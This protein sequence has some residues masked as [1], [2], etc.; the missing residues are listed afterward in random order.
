MEVRNKNETRNNKRHNNIQRR[1]RPKNKPSSRHNS[2]NRRIRHLQKPIRQQHNNTNKQSSQNKKEVGMKT[3]YEHLKKL[4]RH[5]YQGFQIT[6]NVLKNDQYQPTYREA[7]RN[8]NQTVDHRTI[9]SNE[10]IFDLDFRSYTLTYKHVNMITNVLEERKIPYYIFTTGG[11][12][13]HIHTIF[14]KIKLETQEIKNLFTEA[15]SYGFTWKHIRIFLTE[16]ICEEAGINKAYIGKYIDLK[17]INFN[18]LEQNTVL[19]RAAC[20]RNQKYDEITGTTE[21]N[22]KSWIPKEEW[23]NKRIHVKNIEN[24]RYP[25]DIKTFEI[26]IHELGKCLKEYIEDAKTKKVVKQ[27]HV[28]L[29]NGYTGLASVQRIIEGLEEGNRSEGAKILSNAI[30]LDGFS[31]S[32]AEQILKQYTDNC[33]Q[34]GHQFTLSEAMNWYK[35]IKHQPTHFWNNEAVKKLGVW[36]KDT[37]EYHNTVKKT[38]N[39]VLENKGLL[40]RID[41]YLKTVI[42]GEKKTRILLFL[43]L[44]SSKFKVDKE[45]NI[46]GDPKPQSIILSSMS[47]SGKSYITKAI[48]NLFGE[49]EQDYYTF[50][51][52]TST[53]LNYF[54]DID[55][56]GKI[57]FVE[58][59]QGMDKES[60]Q[61]RLW[62]SEGELKLATVEKVEQNGESVNKLVFKENIGQPVFVT[63]TAEDY[64]DEQMNNRSWLI[65]LDVSEEQNRAI[66]EYESDMYS[67][68]RVIDKDELRILKDSIAEL[69]SYHYIIP[70]FN[71]EWLNIPT[72]DVRIRRDFKKFGILIACVTCLFQKQRIMVEDDEG[73]E[74]LI[75][76]IED[77]EIAKKYSEDVL[78]NTF[79]GLTS[80]QLDV[81]EIIKANQWV[82]EF[83]SSDVQ[84]VTGWSQSKTYMTLKQLDEIGVITS[85]SGG[86][87][88]ATKYE[89]NRRKQLVNLKLPSGDELLEI[90]RKNNPTYFDIL[91]KYSTYYQQGTKIAFFQK[92]EIGH[93]ETNLFSKSEQT[94]KQHFI[95]KDEPS[96]PMEKT[97]KKH[98]L[99]GCTPEIGGKKTR[100]QKMSYSKKEIV[101]FIKESKEHMV[102]ENTII[103]EFDEEASEKL[104]KL[105]TDGEVFQPKPGYWMTI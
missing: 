86:V 29:T 22:Y 10:I 70:Y 16:L 100:L 21:T 101:K 47:A 48:L 103:E 97:A 11:K 45:W 56:N 54:S 23:K 33:S 102:A 60:N 40:K 62:I 79:S 71:Y 1:K 76:S 93:D 6:K 31:D 52:M 43:L 92:S 49:K 28:K 96:F 85:H 87:G 46:P 67:N 39:K 35:W 36:D 104:I 91:K 20:G 27:E 55:M 95:Y 19:I 81:L 61:L 64:V 80:Q 69:D 14:D 42:V 15:L 4:E 59:L 73:R 83:E 3:Q 72:S 25:T 2:N 9:A 8:P 57:L 82:D 74:Y 32:R 89:L 94:S 63:G 58:E 38:V 7:L 44:L 17:K 98:G 77:Y 66:L 34:I 99:Q 37:D 51:R 90:V 88:L 78:E 41:D 30:V 26:N 65:S 50:S 53:T 84:R 5:L 105:K 75:S 68:Q 12:G 18:D 24:V 13:V